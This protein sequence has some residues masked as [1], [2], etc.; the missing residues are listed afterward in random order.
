[1]MVLEFLFE[2]IGLTIIVWLTGAAVMAI[3]LILMK[4]W[5]DL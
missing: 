2:L 1:M 5:C 4:W 3:F